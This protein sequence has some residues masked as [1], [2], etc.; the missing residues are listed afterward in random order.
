MHSGSCHCGAVKFKVD[1]AFDSA[2]TCNCSI[3]DRK[4]TVLAFIPGN[5][6]TLVSGDG[7]LTD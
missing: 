6:F 7:A 2:I 1:A 5:A 4:G 3:C